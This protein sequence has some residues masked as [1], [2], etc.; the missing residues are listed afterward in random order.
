MCSA[1]ASTPSVWGSQPAKSPSQSHILNKPLPL[2]RPT[3]AYKAANRLLDELSEYVKEI[4][5][6]F[7][8]LPVTND[9]YEDLIGLR[10]CA[11]KF[12]RR[13]SDRFFL[14]HPGG[15][16]ATDCDFEGLRQAVKEIYRRLWGALPGF[17]EKCGV[18]LLR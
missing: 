4:G 14:Y 5:S 2:R 13:G 7:G 11:E 12:L 6:E 1:K 10:E 18:N 9:R 15:N 3:L 16:V 8:M 17:T